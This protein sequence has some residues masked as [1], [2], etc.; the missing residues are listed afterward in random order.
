MTTEEQQ[1]GARVKDAH[2]RSCGDASTTTQTRKTHMQTRTKQGIQTLR[3]VHAF[4]GRRDFTLAIGD[5]S[6]L[7]A[8][9][10]AVLNTLESH[11]SQQDASERRARELTRKKRE[12]GA[13]LLQ[14]LLRPISLLA[15]A[16]FRDDATL[17]AAFRLPTRRDDE[18]LLQAANAVAERARAHEVRFVAGGFAPDFV[19]R[20]V[21]ATAAFREALVARGLEMGRRSAASA[22]M[23]QELGRGRELVR[24]IDT[25][26]APRLAAHAGLLAE[27]ATITRFARK[28]PDGLAGTPRVSSPVSASVPTYEVA[29][30]PVPGG[31]AA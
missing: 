28:A 10:L 15:R 24:L 31:T 23:L 17:R 30:A 14:E 9:L 29:P 21:T 13:Y 25:M 6:V 1:I 18:G 2:A 7:N 3:R 19:D 16:L 11:A 12:R 8:E 4:M 26:L 22:G 20:V 5:L 27:W